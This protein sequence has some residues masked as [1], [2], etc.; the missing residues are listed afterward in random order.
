VSL[1][2]PEV[3]T[4]LGIGEPAVRKLVQRGRLAPLRPGARPLRFHEAAVAALLPTS[5]RRQQRTNRSQVDDAW[6]EID[7]LVAAQVSG[8]SRCGHAEPSRERSE[9]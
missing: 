4:A 6:A 5:W 1:T 2:T 9:G 3:A 8:V 7:G